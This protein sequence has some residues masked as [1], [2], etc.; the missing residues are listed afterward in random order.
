MLS[1]RESRHKEHHN[2]GPN[3]KHE[4]TGQSPPASGSPRGAGLPRAPQ[5]VPRVAVPSGGARHRHGTASPRC[6]RPRPRAVPGREA[7]AAPPAAL[8]P[9]GAD[10]LR[11]PFCFTEQPRVP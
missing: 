1:A 5:S 9:R 7:G 4:V 10:I 11:M 6:L 8:S 2:S 3:P